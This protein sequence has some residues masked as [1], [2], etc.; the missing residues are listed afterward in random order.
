MTRTRF[1]QARS[2]LALPLIATLAAA[3][4]DPAA[5]CGDGAVDDGETEDNCCVDTGCTFGTCGGAPGDACATP[6]STTCAAGDCD[7]PYVCAGDGSPPGYDCAA[8]RC[9][10]ADACVAGVC[11]DARTRDL[12]RSADVVDNGLSLDEYTRLY[13]D[14]AQQ[15]KLTLGEVAAANAVAMQQDPRRNT[16]VLGAVPGSDIGVVDRAVEGALG[17]QVSRAPLDTPSCDALTAASADGLLPTLVVASVPF[18]AATRQTCPYPGTFPSCA[19]PQA[20]ECVLRAGRFAT[21]FVVDDEKLTLPLL[22][23]AM[24]AR[25]ALVGPDV[26]QAFL[27]QAL[28]HF[29]NAAAVIRPDDGLVVDTRIVACFSSDDP[30]VTFVVIADPNARPLRLGTFRAAWKDPTLQG[31]LLD[32]DITSSACGFSVDGD[33]VSMHCE[34]S[35]GAALDVTVD[36]GDFR[37]IDSS[38]TP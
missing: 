6:W 8:C 34:S 18:D 17:F 9:P 22:D 24:L 2:A 25:A 32:N 4:P 19:V 36:S 21:T 23:Q 33:L 27:D 38:T 15:D 35:F 7:G 16:I 20:A 28:T 5:R 11:L 29:Q 30:F 10:G 13:T 31:F 3:C 1:V 14:F 12:E 37:I 26:M